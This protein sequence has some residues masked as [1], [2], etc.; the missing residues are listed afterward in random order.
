M[1]S[2]RRQI[3]YVF[4]SLLIASMVWFYVSNSDEITVNVHDV[5]IEFLNEDTTLA[6]KGLMRVSGE[7]DMSVDLRLKFPRRLAY[8]FDTSQIRLVCDLSFHHLR[9]QA[10]RGLQHPAAERHFLA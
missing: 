1:K 6:D 7:E 9:G 5:A 3:F 2:K 8:S 4:L 10:D